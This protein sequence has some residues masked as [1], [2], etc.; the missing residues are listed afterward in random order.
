MSPAL[1]EFFDGRIMSSVLWPPR[2][3]DLRP[4]AFYL[5][6]SLKDKLYKTNPHTLEELSY[7]IRRE[8]SKISGEEFQRVKNN[9]FP[10]YTD[11]IRSGG[12]PFQHLL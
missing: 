2:S 4:C 1:R 10:R 7:K 11:C 12:Q 6:R 5:W 3:P 8:I 9:S